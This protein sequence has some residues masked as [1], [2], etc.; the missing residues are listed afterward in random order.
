MTKH[1]RFARAVGP[2]GTVV[3]I[4]ISTPQLQVAEKHFRFGGRGVMG[5]LGGIGGIGNI[6]GIGGIRA[7]GFGIE[8]RAGLGMR[9]GPRKEGPGR[10]ALGGGPWKEGL[11]KPKKSEW[12]KEEQRNALC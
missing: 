1:R 12:F 9:A 2:S 7:R 5:G 4:D 10:R 8:A 11:G 6:G 3:G